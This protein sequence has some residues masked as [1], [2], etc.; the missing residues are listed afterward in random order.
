MQRYQESQLKDSQQEVVS[1]QEQLERV[2]A[3]YIQSQKASQTA[4]I[5]LS[6][7]TVEHE[8]TVSSLR[9]ELQSLRENSN[10][11]STVLELQEK[12]AEMEE[13]LRAKCLEIEEN[14]DRFID[15]LK[16]KKKLTAKI[17]SLNRKISTLQNKLNATATPSPPSSSSLPPIPGSSS[18]S[19]LA[20]PIPSTVLAPALPI[21]AT[22]TT[23]SSRTRT[24]SGASGLPRPKTPDAKVPPPPVF[25][26]R[27][28]EAKRQPSKPIFM[29]PPVFSP[30][31]G[32]KR[33]A[34]D[35][36]DDY[37]GIPAQVFTPE[38]IPGQ[39]SEDKMPGIR[40]ALHTM[41]TGFTPARGQLPRSTPTQMSPT[42]RATTG[43][44]IIADVTNS[45]RAASTASL[46][47]KGNKRGWLGK[48]RGGPSQPARSVSSRP[49]V[50][51][52][53]QSDTFR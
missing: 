6:F 35:D 20:H 17:D 49:V 22:P 34:P 19:S 16:E 38:S 40:K 47:E 14:D 26:A 37:D 31:T 7:Q 3:D 51:G 48:I 43:V 23:P 30:S 4:E 5:N 25:K 36:F 53:E 10:L 32:K 45:P 50:F 8:K 12:N 15:M 18:A 46:P 1:L 9:R 13:L 24:I 11:Q 21:R 39:V 44:P 42:R 41:R 28:P 33:R 29:D 2:K 52:R 27:T